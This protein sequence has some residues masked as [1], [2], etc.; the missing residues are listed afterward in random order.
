MSTSSSIDARGPRFNA[1]VTSVLLVVVVATAHLGAGVYVLAIQAA[2]FA[3]G[4]ILGVQRTPLAW[5]FRRFVR[6][7][8]GPT[9][10][11]ED[12]RPPRFAQ[13][14]GLVFA[15]LGI[16]GFTAGPFWLGY[17]A[18]GLALVA[19]LLNATVQF[20]LGCQIYGVCK[21]PQNRDI[22]LAATA[23]DSSDQSI[24][25]NKKEAVA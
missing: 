4:V 18:T 24:T 11:W 22:T 9:A 1:A 13:G 6:P 25:N 5:V 12:P 7:S 2:L 17:V 20:C 10:D 8:L 14:I 19:A 3:S 21:L 15:V 23:T 16:V